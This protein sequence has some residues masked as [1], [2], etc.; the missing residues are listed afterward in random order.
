M[1]ILLVLDLSYGI[2]YNTVSSNG[3]HI[4]LGPVHVECVKAEVTVIFAFTH[5]K[6]KFHYS[7]PRYICAVEH[8]IY[9][10]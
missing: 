1:P 8:K 10:L 6:F 9:M 3:T 4:P 5:R 2:I 7:K